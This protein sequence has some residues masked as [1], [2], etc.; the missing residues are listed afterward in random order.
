[1]LASSREGEEDMLLAALVAANPPATPVQWLIVPRHP[2]RFDEVAQR[3]AAHGFKVLRRSEWGHEGQGDTLPAPGNNTVWLGDSLAEMTLYYGISDLALLGGSFAPLGGQ[4][5]IEAAA[6]GCPVVMGGIPST[7]PRRRTWRKNLALR[8][9]R[10]TCAPQWSQ[11][12]NW[13]KTAHSA[14]PCRLRRSNSSRHRKARRCVPRRLFCYI[15]SSF[16]C[17]I[18][19]RYSLI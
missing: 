16:L 19:G 3:I 18:D 6:C 5:L 14:R 9:A 13:H 10:P 2:Q 17:T 7:S 8:C 15:F 11:P 4:N 12:L 1:M